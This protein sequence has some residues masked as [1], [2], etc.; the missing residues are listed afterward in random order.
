MQIIRGVD[1]GSGEWLDIRL[2]KVTASKFKDVMAGGKGA[3]RK[4]Y[5]LQL[6]AEIITGMKTDTFKNKAMEWGT[7]TED[8]ARANYELNESLEVEEVSFV[9]HDTLSAGVSP[10][11]LVGDCGLVEFKCPNTTTQIETFLSGKMPTTH[12]A[13]VQGQLWI[14]EREWCDFV[15]YDPRINGAAEYFCVRINRDDEYIKTLEE[16]VIKFIN[17]LNELVGKLR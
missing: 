5:M 13:Q 1:Q 15:S 14:T 6:A 10:D 11:G 2:G 17:E 3:T 8:Q 12:K 16:G 4:A 9:L 7:E